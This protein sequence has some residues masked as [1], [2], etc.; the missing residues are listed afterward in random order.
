MSVPSR[1]RPITPG[2]LAG[3]VCLALPFHAASA[4]QDSTV[5]LA[6]APRWAA[7][8][9]LSSREAIE[10]ELS[11]PL[12]YP[13]EQLALLIGTIDVT[14]VLEVDRELV[15]YRPAGNRL[16]AGELEV[17]A[18]LISGGRWQEVGR[19]P[20]KV[21][22]RVGLDRGRILPSLDLTS[23]GQLDQGGTDR[24]PPDRRTYQDLTLRIGL[25]T[26]MTRGGWQLSAAGNAVGVSQKAQRLRWGDLQE[27]APPVDLSDYRVSVARGGSSLMIGNLTAGGHRYLLDGFASRGAALG[28]RFGSAVSVE[29]LLVNG[30]NV[31]GWNNPIGLTEPAHRIASATVSVDLL[32]SRPGGMR[33]A[34]SGVDG[35]VLPQTGFN[36]GAA[37][38]AEES[39]GLGA[40]VTLSDVGQRIRFA[41][42][43]ARSRFVNPADPLLAD[44]NALVP[45][46]PTSRT[47]RYAELTLQLLR[48]LR[49]NRSIAA[50]LGAGLRHERVDPLYRSVGASP[51]ADVEKNGLDLTGSIGALALQ[52]ALL[53]VRDNLAGLRSI[54]TTRTRNATLSAALPLGALL[55]RGDR[56]YF[57]Q[58][59]FSWQRSH[60]YGEGIPENG[61]FSA[62]HVPDQVSVSRSTAVAWTYEASTLTYRWD[63]SSQD[64][65]Q[66]GRERADFRADVH[67]I[68]VSAT[69]DPGVQASIDLSI[70][71][72]RSVEQG[73]T[74]RLERVGT[75]LRWEATRTTELA[76]SLS[77]SWA[78]DPGTA[79]RARNTE[80]QLEVSQG[81]NLYRRPEGG[82]QGRVFVRFSRARAAVYV[83]TDPGVLDVRWTLAAGGSLRLY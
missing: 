31:V 7:D 4:Q 54:L 48:G 44:G 32:P 71:R 30:S 56:W 40:Q 46:R 58:L 13:T 18:Y 81:M 2:L 5:R 72:Q 82:T 39:R 53:R 49:L 28:T 16:P 57:P 1:P 70:E 60:Q 6:L 63:R 67:G 24:T 29:A 9:F 50:T 22:T 19:F 42:G 66:A 45:V 47:A 41:G 69:P 10:L 80:L 51:Q 25:E 61:D 11:R 35:S 27:Q 17:T 23:T 76:G 38:D 15:R 62:S 73:I 3:L 75:S 78:T 55:T 59:S 74:Q 68:S 20:L 21:R 34:L 65:R 37:T 33:L 36:E 12:R 79:Q 14:N 64:N 8:Q 26:E 52:A 43:L 83:P 77:Q